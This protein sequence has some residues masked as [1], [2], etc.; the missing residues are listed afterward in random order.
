[1]GEYYKDKKR[2]LLKRT[3]IFL[4]ATQKYMLYFCHH[5]LWANKS[6]MKQHDIYVFVNILLHFLKTYSL[7]VKLKKVMELIYYR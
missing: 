1:M 6:V 7:P 3:R 4:S 5:A 2:L